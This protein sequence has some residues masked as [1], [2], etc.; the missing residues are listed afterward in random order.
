MGK[1]YEFDDG[2]HSYE[3]ISRKANSKITPTKRSPQKEA[4]ANY[5][6]IIN[7]SFFV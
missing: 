6:D 3:T 4:D 1:A 2:S 7:Y 5:Q